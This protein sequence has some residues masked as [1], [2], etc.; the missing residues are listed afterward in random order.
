M[1]LLT[2]IDSYAWSKMFLTRHRIQTKFSILDRLYPTS[3]L[4]A[5]SLVDQEAVRPQFQSAPS[6]ELSLDAVAQK[7]GTSNKVAI[8]C[9]CKK[10]CNPRSRYR[11][12]KNPVKRSQYCH[13]SRRDCSNASAILQG[14]DQVALSRSERILII[15]IIL[16]PLIHLT[17]N[18]QTQPKDAEQTLFLLE[19]GANMTP[20]QWPKFKH[21]CYLTMENR[22]HCLNLQ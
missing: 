22:L 8:T 11:C 3:E 7:V 2:I 15:Q 20:K 4:N 9:G 1:Q 17:L 13:S 19:K 14:T 6:K 16:R 12:R 5:V 21:R 10:S 18:K